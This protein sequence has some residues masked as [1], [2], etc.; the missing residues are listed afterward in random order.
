VAAAAAETVA[1]ATTMLSLLLPI[2]CCF[3]VLP[4][5][6]PPFRIE[7]YSGPG[8]YN[9]DSDARNLR[10]IA[11]RTRLQHDFAEARRKFKLAEWRRRQR[12]PAYRAKWSGDYI[13]VSW[14]PYACAEH[15][16]VFA[17]FLIETVVCS[18]SAQ[19]GSML[20]HRDHHIVI[21]R[22]GVTEA[23]QK[24]PPPCRRYSQGHHVAKTLC[25]ILRRGKREALFNVCRKYTN[26]RSEANNRY[27]AVLRYAGGSIGFFSH[28]CHLPVYVELKLANG[29]AVRMEVRLRTSLLGLRR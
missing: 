13:E 8:K 27:E 26:S 9:A 28:V 3:M 14:R 5:L 4:A 23:V 2:A 15:T 16:T 1:M 10:A 11:D 19:V 6:A 17:Q 12:T 18:F 20:Y 24:A 7:Y 29:T 22:G 25:T 21:S